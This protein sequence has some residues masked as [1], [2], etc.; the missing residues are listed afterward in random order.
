M[1][2]FLH[3]TRRTHLYLGIFLLPWFFMYGVT[4]I[5]FSH[6]AWV[7]QRFYS[8]AGPE[9]TPRVDKPYD[10]EIPEGNDLR[11]TGERMLKDAGIEPGA[12]GAYREGGG[13]V[14]VYRHDFWR[15]TRITYFPDQKRLKAED[16]RFRWDHFLTGM[17]ARGGFDQSSV[18]ND[19][20]ALI[21][22]LVC[23]S[24]LVW[25]VSGLVM[26]WQIPGHRRWGFVAIAAGAAAFA[27]FLVRL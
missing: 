10:I 3:I 12:F 16:K 15:A 25:I 4:S 9:W 22:D 6:A 20:W 21:I 26:W 17:H 27:L 24:M 18:L 23:L 13:R 1:A 11:S 8:N 14:S 7:Q 2:K 19:A 5:P